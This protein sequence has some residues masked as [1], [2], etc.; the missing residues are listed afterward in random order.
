MYPASIYLE[1]SPQRSDIPMGVDRAVLRDICYR[2]IDQ[3]SD[4]ALDKRTLSAIS[5]VERMTGLRLFPG[6]FEARFPVW[7]RDGYYAYSDGGR[8]HYLSPNTA[9]WIPGVSA[10]LLAE[11]AI[12][13]GDTMDVTPG[14]QVLDEV[15]NLEVQAPEKGWPI[16]T[17]SDIKDV[18]AVRFQAGGRPPERDAQGVVTA[19]AVSVPD[20]VVEVIGLQL[21][22]LFDQ[23]PQDERA[24][25]AR[26]KYYAYQLEL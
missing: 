25:R 13:V 11:D 9:L 3:T 26:A 12:N 7:R 19:N 10:K 4:S 5:D 22:W 16:T 17:S 24:A 14:R 18:I 6:T 2:S 23:E 8:G 21:K 15:G 20:A 1:T